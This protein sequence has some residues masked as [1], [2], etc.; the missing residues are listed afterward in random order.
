MIGIVIGCL[1]I[2]VVG[3]A[4]L[5]GKYAQLVLFASGIFM[6]LASIAFDTG[7]FMPKKAVPTGNEILNVVEFLRYTFSN[8][9]SELGLLIM[10]M[11]GFASYMTHI[12]ANDAFVN[13]A[14]KP[15]SIIKHPYA[16]VFL[17]FLLGKAVSMVITSAVGLGVLCLALM[18]PALA[19]LGMNKKTIGAVFVTSGAASMVLLGGTTAASAKACGIPILDYVFIYKI[20]AALPTVLCMALAHVFWQRYLDHKEGWVCSEHR[21]ETL[22]FEEEVKAPSTAAPKIYALL[23][24][25]PMILVV[26][27]SEYGIKG[28]KLHI[29]ALMFL[30]HFPRQSNNLRYLKQNLSKSNFREVLF[31]EEKISRLRAQP[32]D[33]RLV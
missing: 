26:V 5:K 8:R 4:I 29:T 13:I 6:L 21:G 27:F 23:P 18:G 17:A 16:L 24:F 7:T 11:V 33:P 31:L 19:A 10:T 9:L 12:G 1:T 22:T 15:L 28:I 14:I 3:W 25:L 30:F 20:P 32:K 2:V